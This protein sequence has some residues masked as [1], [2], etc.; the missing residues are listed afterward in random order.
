MSE[1]EGL[2]SSLVD[3]HLCEACCIVIFM[4]ATTL[5]DSLETEI[6]GTNVAFKVIFL[7]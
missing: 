6:P 1:V 5:L 2:K 7:T 4:S 3:P